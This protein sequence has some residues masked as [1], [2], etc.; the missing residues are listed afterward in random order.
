MFPN[1]CIICLPLGVN[2]IQTRKITKRPF[3]RKIVKQKNDVLACSKREHWKTV[4]KYL[5][6]GLNSNFMTLQPFLTL[7]YGLKYDRKTFL[8]FYDFSVILTR[9]IG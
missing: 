5:K 3:I 2:I 9:V 6:N 8:R 7:K 4:I 1:I